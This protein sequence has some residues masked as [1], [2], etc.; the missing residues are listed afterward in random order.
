M[1]PR[2]HVALTGAKC[3]AARWGTLIAERCR[4]HPAPANK[5]PPASPL[6]PLPPSLVNRRGANEKIYA[7]RLIKPNT[8][9]FSQ[10]V[11]FAGSL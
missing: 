10:V 6:F 5:P 7:R 4:Y 2:K 9:A 1:T 11:I 3:G 8:Q